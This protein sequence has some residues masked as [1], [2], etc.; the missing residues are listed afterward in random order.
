LASQGKAP[1]EVP[2]PPR[3]CD[4]RFFSSFWGDHWRRFSRVSPPPSLSPPSSA[5]NI[6]AP[7]FVL[8][9][10]RKSPPNEKVFIFHHFFQTAGK[11]SAIIDTV[12][13]IKTRAPRGPL[14]PSVPTGSP[15][16]P[17]GPPKKRPGSPPPSPAHEQ[18]VSP[19]TWTPQP[20][21]THSE[22]NP[23]SK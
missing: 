15:N 6:R 23:R 7:P 14:I 20:S 8:R 21:S 16:R 19:T 3:G 5:G 12:F 13:L 9:G 2:P 1:R 17:P 22:E 10:T 4:F 11:P 18:T